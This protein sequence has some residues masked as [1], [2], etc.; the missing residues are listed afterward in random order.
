MMGS[1]HAAT[2]ALT[3][4]LCVSAFG[5]D[6]ITVAAGAVLGAGAALVSDL[7]HGNSCAT[8]AHGPFTKIPSRILVA[9]SKFSYRNTRTAWEKSHLP[10][11]D[12]GGHRYLTHT[13][14]FAAVAG[15]ATYG[16]S[17]FWPVRLV[18][19]FLLISFAVRGLCQAL[20]GSNKIDKWPVRSIVSAAGAWLLPVSPILLG[21]L[22]TVG[23]LTHI[24][25]D[26]LTKAGTPILWPVK[27]RGQR[28]C[29]LR[30][31]ITITTGK[32]RAEPIIS[33]A[34][35]ISSVILGLYLA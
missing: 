3:G 18:I 7:D 15:L 30:T 24:V 28:W 14:I 4:V 13:G 2:G 12:P 26:S 5:G 34:S 20:P 27:I 10:N 21:A 23:I 33:W 22:M 25:A 6:L 17:I 9:L 1:S 19:E 11:H 35:M 29:R 31:P 16:G 32:S 8:L